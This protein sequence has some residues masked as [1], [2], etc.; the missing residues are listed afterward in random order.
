MW[1]DLVLTRCCGVCVL[2]GVCCVLC[3]VSGVV[4][5]VGCGVSGVSAEG[6]GV[7]DQRRFAGSDKERRETER[8][9]WSADDHRRAQAKL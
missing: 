1:R 4:S 8:G 5:G 9:K 2:C 7:H 3:G 6:A